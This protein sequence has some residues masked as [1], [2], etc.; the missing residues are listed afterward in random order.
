[1]TGSL[2]ASLGSDTQ[3]GGHSDHLDPLSNGSSTALYRRIEFH[4]ARKAFKGFSN[5]GGDF[6][7]ETLNP[8]SSSEQRRSG[9]SPGL[10]VKKVDGSEFLENGLDPELSF[11]ITVRRIVSGLVGFH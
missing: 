5:G 7:L 4:P 3:P 8:G 1:M 11:G 6:R 2:V 10:T 9:S